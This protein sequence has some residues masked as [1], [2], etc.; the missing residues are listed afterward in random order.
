MGTAV[1]RRAAGADSPLAA[2]L[3]ATD[4]E[5]RPD[6][7]EVAEAEGRANRLIA[8]LHRGGA[9]MYRV[10]EIIDHGSMSRGTALRGFRDLDKL[11]VLDPQALLTTRGTP[12]T[13]R[14]TIQRMAGAIE[15]R[16]QGL[17]NQGTIVV[18]AQDHSVGVEYPA[19][20]FRIDL[21]PAVREQGRL[22]IPEHGSDRWIPTDPATTKSRLTRAKQLAPHAGIV[23][24][25]LKGWRRARGQHAPLRSFAV[26]T[27]VV[28]AVL[29]R[30]DTLDGLVY[31]FFAEIA[32]QPANRRLALGAG[33]ASRAPVVVVDPVSGGNLASDL[34]A[35]HRVALIRAGRVAVEQL[36]EIEA[37][38]EAGQARSALSGSR[39]L[40]VGRH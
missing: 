14:D 18:R 33:T 23:V 15:S 7:A 25:L 26:E 19:T 17:V 39:R 29:S 24:R 28:D 22:L 12:R 38:A 5:L 3:R 34:R 35:S 36:S 6:A 20:G 21:V 31:N 40:F 30:P 11:V 9:W 8:E 37:L 2:V 1:T 4:E 13:P 32:G 27:L 10:V 16:R